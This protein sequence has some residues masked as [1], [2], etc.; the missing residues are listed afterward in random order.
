MI[1]F[2]SHQKQDKC[3]KTA[4]CKSFISF[5]TLFKQH[6]E[7]AH[8]GFD[9]KVNSVFFCTSFFH[10]PLMQRVPTHHWFK[11][12]SLFSCR[13]RLTNPSSPTC[14]KTA[15]LWHG[16]PTLTREELQSPPTSLR[17]SGEFHTLGLWS[18][19]STITKPFFFF[20]EGGGQ[21]L[22]SNLL[23][24]WKMYFEGSVGRNK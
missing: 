11:P 21:N 8:I 5:S 23:S 22:Y 15:F 1:L 9:L 10:L 6:Y 12:R 24:F 20:W 14:P 17:P 7:R 13:V 2:G 16:N 19:R 18:T 4:A 3:W